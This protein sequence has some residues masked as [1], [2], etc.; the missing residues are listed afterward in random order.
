MT[1][2]IV[3][4]V[5]MNSVADVQ[6]N[7]AVAG[8]LL[9]EAAEQGAVLAVLPENFA[10]QLLDAQHLVFRHAVLLATR[11]N[12]CVHLLYLILAV[13]EEPVG[14]GSARSSRGA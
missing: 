11:A 6:R 12:D 4:A 8:A 9:A 2:P 14:A 1:D 13:H 5:Q 3:A 10:F 7:L